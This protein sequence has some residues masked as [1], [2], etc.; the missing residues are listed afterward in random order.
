MF[1]TCFQPNYLFALKGKLVFFDYDDARQFLTAHLG[2]QE[3][4]G[5][6]G[7]GGNASDSD[8]KNHWRI[9]FP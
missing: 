8:Y 6:T 1:P 7:I 9:S 3:K 5:G 4:A 2:E